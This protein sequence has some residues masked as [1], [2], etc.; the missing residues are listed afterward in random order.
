M[1]VELRIV[2]YRLSRFEVTISTHLESLSGQQKCIRQGKLYNIS[3]HF[4][5]PDDDLKWVETCG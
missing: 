5:V 3:C 4:C 2:E 1:E